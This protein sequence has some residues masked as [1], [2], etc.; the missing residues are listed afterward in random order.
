MLNDSKILYVVAEWPKV[1]IDHWRALLISRAI[2]NQCFV[3]ACNRVGSDPNNVFGG[4]SMIIGPWGEIIAEA[5]E[6]ETIIHADIDLN[7]VHQVRNTIP[8]LQDRRPDIYE[9]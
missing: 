2:E 8:I 4:H 5:G 3:V 1:R 7:Q 9:V 6:E